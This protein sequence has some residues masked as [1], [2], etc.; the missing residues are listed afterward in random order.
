MP[1]MT[2]HTFPKNLAPGIEAHLGRNQKKIKTVY[3]R[4]FQ[5]KKTARAWMEWVMT[6][7]LGPAKQKPEGTATELDAMAQGWSA[8]VKVVTW[9]LGFS[10][11]REA[12]EDDLYADPMEIGT[13]ELVQ[14]FA[15]AKEIVHASMLNFAFDSNYPMGDGVS[16][17]NLSHPT[18]GHDTP[19]Y[20]NT[21]LV[22]AD[23]S[24]ASIEQAVIDIQRM[25]N[26]RGIQMNV[27]ATTLVLPTELQFEEVRIMRNMNRPG[28]ADR[29]ISALYKKGILQN[30][31]I[32]WKFLTDPKMVTILTSLNEDEG[33]VTANR[34]AFESDQWGD[35][36]T[37]NFFVTARERY[38]VGMRNPRSA[39][40]F[41][42]S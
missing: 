39:F 9:G 30:E 24:E 1:V 33:F 27:E 26:E 32:I 12:I 14:S 13:R 3:N 4:I 25:K 29:D 42:G 41:T 18:I 8:Y 31:P 37:G 36:R 34:I 28:T 35:D 15:E 40:I 22:Q 5:S 19:N 16:L 20:R 6:A 21:L 23:F 17:A 11:T 7:G 38:G 2:R 10:I